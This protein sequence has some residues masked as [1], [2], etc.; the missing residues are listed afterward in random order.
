LIDTVGS[1]ERLCWLAMTAK[2][3][4]KKGNRKEK[5]KV[6]KTGLMKRDI[7]EKRLIGILK[8]FMLWSRKNDEMGLIWTKCH[9][10]F[11]DLVKND[12]LPEISYDV[13]ERN[14]SPEFD[15]E[16]VSRVL[17]K[18]AVLKELVKPKIRI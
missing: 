8:M 10:E 2:V 17:F 7:D 3:E 15:R 11:Y 4:R 12:M 13:R 9:K 1:G 5:I 18:K 6:I 14:A 16:L